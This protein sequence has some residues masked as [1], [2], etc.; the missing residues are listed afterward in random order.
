M[1]FTLRIPCSPLMLHGLKQVAAK[2][3]PVEPKVVLDMDTNRWEQAWQEAASTVQYEGP[4]PSQGDP[5]HL[6]THGQLDKLCH[7]IGLATEIYLCETCGIKP[8]QRKNTW[9]GVAPPRVALAPLLRSKPSTAYYFSPAA[10][11]WSALASV[12]S[13]CR[14]LIAAQLPLADPV[15][16]LLARLGPKCPEFFAWWTASHVSWMICTW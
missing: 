6:A 10:S 15:W 7:A 14:K 8:G 13:V 11:F 1:G 4:P 5:A 3:F 9:A 2:T 12:L 16:G